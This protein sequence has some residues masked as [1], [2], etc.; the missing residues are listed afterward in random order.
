MACLTVDHNENHKDPLEWLETQWYGCNSLYL[1]ASGSSIRYRGRPPVPYLHLLPIIDVL[2]A[3]NYGAF[4]C[5][6]F[7]L[8]SPVIIFL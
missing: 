3:P 4:F 7:E 6:F 5:S 1:G 2:K 8:M